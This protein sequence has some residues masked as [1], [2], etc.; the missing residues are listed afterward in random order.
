MHVIIDCMNYNDMALLIKSRMNE[1][2]INQSDLAQKSKLSASQIS[3]ILK[4]ES[5]PGQEAITAIARA[6]QLP[7]DTVFRAAGILPAVSELDEYKAK[8]LEETKDMT[9]QEKRSL[10][11]FIRSTKQ[12]RVPSPEQGSLPLSKLSKVKK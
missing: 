1:L 11:A 4:L 10:L 8:I 5:T 12:M 2:G 9:E 7:A 6:L 3:R